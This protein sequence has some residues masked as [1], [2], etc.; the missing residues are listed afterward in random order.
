LKRA[1]LVVVTVACGAAARDERVQPASS[2]SAPASAVVVP[3]RPAGVI[4][5][6]VDLP[7]A[8]HAEHRSLAALQAS[9]ERLA[10][11]NVRVIVTPMF[12]PRAYARSPAE[13]RAAYE[14]TYADVPRLSG[15]ERWLS[16]EG[17]DGFADEPSSIDAWIARGACLV[18]LVHDHS[19]ALGGASQDPDRAARARGLTEAGKKLAAHVVAKGALLDAAHASDATFDDLLQ[20][21]RNAGAPLVVSHTGLRTRREIM[22]NID[23]AQMREVASAGGVIGISMHSGHIAREAGE[24]AT[25]GDVAD[26]IAYA[27]SVAGK[28]HVAIGSDFDGDITAPE[29]ANGEAVWPRMHDELRAR[30]LSEDTID[31][32]F[33]RNAARVFA[34]ARA[35]GCTPGSR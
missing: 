28:D 6:H 30:G 20:I 19:N 33:E 22:R 23:D 7:Y 31:A 15:T 4:D 32:I 24:R 18:G 3:Q 35:H 11:G 21:A 17:A 26:A 14:A 1:L 5:L 8:I 10:A 2:A 16:F 34:F 12:V 27:A 29:D 13:A 25:L 9:P